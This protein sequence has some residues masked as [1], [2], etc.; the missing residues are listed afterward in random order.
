MARA[1]KKRP[2]AMP[3][4]RLSALLVL[5]VL[6]LA[7]PAAASN[8][9]DG[10]PA[11][12]FIVGD[13]HVEM[14]GPSLARR[15]RAQGFDVLGHESRRGWSTMRYREEGDLREL[16]VRAGRPELVVVSLG[17]NDRVESAEAYAEHLRWIVGE[18]RAA[19]AQRI[20]WLGPATSDARRGARAAATSARHERNADWQR[21][22]LPRLD[23][24]F[25]DSRP[26]TVE[27]HARDGIH[28]DRTGY[29]AWADA[30]LPALES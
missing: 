5:L 1:L 7:S 13:S 14:L 15:L 12:V 9:G 21:E 18:A 25:V 2:Y 4:R 29:A 27:H 20:V 28:F 16:L 3:T 19:G 30:V 11:R 8:D 10:R 26:F 24:R 22:I 6:A 17:G 23:V